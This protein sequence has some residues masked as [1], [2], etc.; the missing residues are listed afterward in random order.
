MSHVSH[1]RAA[2]LALALS[3]LPLVLFPAAAVAD[4]AP[5]TKAAIE[6]VEQKAATPTHPSKAQVEHDELVPSGRAGQQ[7]TPSST[8]S[9]GGADATAWQLALSAA[10][11]ALITGGVVVGSRRF[12]HDGAAVAS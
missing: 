9:S 1:R 7:V 4:T 2:T 6:H 12:G 5:S 11:G 8:G 10:L 3:T